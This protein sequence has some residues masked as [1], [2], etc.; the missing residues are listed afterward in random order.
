MKTYIVKTSSPTNEML[1]HSLMIEE[2]ETNSFEEAEQVFINE[3]KILAETYKKVS[4]LDYSPTDQE[5][6]H[7]ISCE[8]ISLS[9]EEDFEYIKCSELYL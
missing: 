6:Q 9:S 3:E 5:M 1:L 8:I 4:N 7:A 2:F